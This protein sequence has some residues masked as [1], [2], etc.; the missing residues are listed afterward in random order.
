M[1]QAFNNR[2]E[3]DETE[4]S[5]A[6]LYKLYKVSQSTD[7]PYTQRKKVEDNLQ[8]YR[9]KRRVQQSRRKKA[10]WERIRTGK[11]TAS[12]LR[13]QASA[14]KSHDK[15][16]KAN[17]EQVRESYRIYKQNKRKQKKGG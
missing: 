1:K 10:M 11:P 6:G 17:Q 3:L 9:I 12:D 15:W 14:R 4:V 8:N 7:F 2:N 5:C 13:A 16:T